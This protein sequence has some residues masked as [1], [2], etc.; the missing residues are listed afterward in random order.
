MLTLLPTEEAAEEKKPIFRIRKDED[1][2]ERMVF[3]EVLVPETLDTYGDYH[4]RQ[5]IREFAYAFM[6][7]GFGIDREHDNNDISDKAFVVESFIARDGDPDFIPG[8]WVVGMYIADDETWDQVRNHELN[9]YSYEAL[10][11]ALEIEIEMP[12]VSVATGFTEPD[13]EDGHI[14]PYIVFFDAEGKIIAGGTTEVDGHSHP[15]RRHTFTQ[16]GNFHIHIYNF[17]T[18]EGGL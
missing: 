12:V 9:G 7:H 11:K 4:T 2:F 16:E 1:G 14:H 8:A 13:L 10:V 17:L 18:G 15:I 5:S 6:V 3:G